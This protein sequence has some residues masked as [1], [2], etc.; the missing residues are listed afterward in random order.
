VIVSDDVPVLSGLRS[1]SARELTVGQNVHGLT[2][3]IDV[4][5]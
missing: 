5:L 3:L 1:S 4:C 2:A